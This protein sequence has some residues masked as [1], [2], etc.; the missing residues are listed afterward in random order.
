MLRSAGFQS[1]H[2]RTILSSQ[3]QSGSSECSG[4]LVFPL[5]TSPFL[6]SRFQSAFSQ[7]PAPESAALPNAGGYCFPVP[8]RSG[9]LPLL[10]I[11]QY[12]CADSRLPTSYLN[13]QHWRCSFVEIQMYLPASQAD[14][15]GV[16]DGLVDIQLDSG[17]Q[18]K[19][20]PLVFHHLFPSLN[21][22]LNVW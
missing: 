1:G 12:L 22:S 3:Y 8:K 14:F 11:L 15:K 4:A 21:S 6:G 5:V 17:D 9:S 16:Q 18:L 13:T 20:G 2:A 10:F 7:V 19:K